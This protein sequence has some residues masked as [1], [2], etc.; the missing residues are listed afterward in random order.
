MSQVSKVIGSW[1]SHTTPHEVRGQQFY[2][3]MYSLQDCYISE[4]QNNKQTN[5]ILP[6]LC[7]DLREEK[8]SIN[9]RQTH[10]QLM[11]C[12]NTSVNSEFL[13]I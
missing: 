8:K 4:K 2:F 12:P 6:Q 7:N 10:T 11:P 3:E 5:P 9:K 1:I 13:F